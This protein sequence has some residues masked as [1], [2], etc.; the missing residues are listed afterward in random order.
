MHS[1]LSPRTTVEAT[2]GTLGPY[3]PL[4][5]R[6]V[7]QL[8]WLS[9]ERDPP[10]SQIRLQKTLRRGEGGVIPPQNH[11]QPRNAPVLRAGAVS[12]DLRAS[13]RPRPGVPVCPCGLRGSSG[14]RGRSLPSPA[15]KPQ[16]CLSS[17]LRQPLCSLPPPRP[18]PG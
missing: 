17:A 4:Y 11:G 15:L 3:P 12:P 14:S 7:D 6:S 2:R 1:H 9:G 13:A 10:L 18:L 16:P 8:W 5:P